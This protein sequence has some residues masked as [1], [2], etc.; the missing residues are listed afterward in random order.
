MSH[1]S[2]KRWGLREMGVSAENGIVGRHSSDYQS[3]RPWSS[4]DSEGQCYMFFW[5]KDLFDIKR[6]H[7]LTLRLFQNYLTFFLVWNTFFGLSIQWKSIGSSVLFGFQRSSEYLHLCSTGERKT[8]RFGITWGLSEWCQNFCFCLNC[9][10]K[11]KAH[12]V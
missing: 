9:P 8:Y 5:A 6:D 10:F 2:L 11:M 4:L 7:L 3:D 12:K 1:L